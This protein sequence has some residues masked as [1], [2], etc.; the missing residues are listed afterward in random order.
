MGVVDKL[1]VAIDSFKVAIDSFKVSTDT[2]KVST[3]TFKAAIDASTNYIISLNFFKARYRFFV[4]KKILADSLLFLL[5][6]D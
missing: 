2:S 5:A 3:D 6:I 1:M 4:R